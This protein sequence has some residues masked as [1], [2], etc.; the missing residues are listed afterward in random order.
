[1]TKTKVIEGENGVYYLEVCND[2]GSFLTI[3][4]KLTKE[5]LTNLHTAMA[6]Y[7]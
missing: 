2:L 6:K 4:I 1:M 5:E 3:K 7:I